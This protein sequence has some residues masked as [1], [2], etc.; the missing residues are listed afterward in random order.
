MGN[1]SVTPVSSEVTSSAL[2]RT[3]V[4]I[5]DDSAAIRSSL[6]ALIARLPGVEIVGLAQT[7]SEAL[8]L[9]RTLKPHVVTLDLRMPGMSGLNV[10]GAIQNDQFKPTIIVL[11]GLAEMEYQRKCLELG[12]KFFF[13]KSTEFEKVIEILTDH[14]RHL[15]Q[16]ESHSAPSNCS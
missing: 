6:A 14:S 2:K 10:L 4:L 8:E 7:G 9:V 12:A 5:A 15:N 11:T 16:P 13:H 3:R 1:R